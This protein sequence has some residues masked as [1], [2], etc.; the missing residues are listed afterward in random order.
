MPTQIFR[1]VAVLAAL[2][3]AAPCFA[4]HARVVASIQRQT[5]SR[6]ARRSLAPDAGLAMKL[7][8]GRVLLPTQKQVETYFAKRP[9]R[10]SFIYRIGGAFYIVPRPLRTYPGS[11]YQQWFPAAMERVRSNC[12]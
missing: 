3:I 1:S 11:C 4:Q 6:D 7:D 8:E 10:S 12:S 2:L 5:D 9:D